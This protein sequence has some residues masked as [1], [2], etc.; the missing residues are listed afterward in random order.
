MN[1]S[2]LLNRIIWKCEN[3]QNWRCLDRL[4]HYGLIMRY[5]EIN[6]EVSEELKNLLSK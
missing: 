2:D 1:K 5:V 4:Q 6:F 3:H